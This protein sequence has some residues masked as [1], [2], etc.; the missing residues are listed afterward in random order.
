VPLEFRVKVQRVGTS[1]QIV[2]P[3]PMVDGFKIRQGD[4]MVLTVD[5]LSISV[6]KQPKA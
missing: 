5:G 2:I 4:V 3:K 6:K 1:L